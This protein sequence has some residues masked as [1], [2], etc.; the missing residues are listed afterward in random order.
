MENLAKQRWIVQEIVA[1][2]V[3]AS[4]INA[5]L[6]AHDGCCCSIG[7]RSGHY[8]CQV[9]EGRQLLHHAIRRYTVMHFSNNCFGHHNFVFESSC[10][11]SQV[12]L[13]LEC[14]DWVPN[15]IVLTSR[16]STHSVS[17][18]GE[19]IVQV[20]HECTPEQAACSCLQSWCQLNGV[21]W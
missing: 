15:C 5:H 21:H 14:S 16:L 9:P 3:P 18:Q 11:Y 19:V 8:G 1:K 2:A 17:I 20:M 7:T 4:A 10:P 13:Q 6:D 12:P